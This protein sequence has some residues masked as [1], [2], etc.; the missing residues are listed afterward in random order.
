MV[1]E[2]RKFLG[3]QYL[4]AGTSG[5]GFD[6]SGFTHSVYLAYGVTI[7]RDAD[8]QA[9][10]GTPVA[11]SDL[12]PGDLVFF[13]ASPSGPIGHVGMYVG[14][15]EMIDAPHTGAPVRIDSVWSFGNY[16]GARRYLG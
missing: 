13:R 4:W 2:A 8:R 14:S 5:F 11:A 9:V 3:L 6:C 15:G 10:R 16:A 12:K 1:A 7:P